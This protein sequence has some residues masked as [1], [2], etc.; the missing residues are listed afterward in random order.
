[1]SNHIQK[2]VRDGVS[3][4]GTWRKRL[5]KQSERSWRIITNGTQVLL[6]WLLLEWRIGT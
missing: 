4:R 5:T 1:M 6:L 2:R 3:I